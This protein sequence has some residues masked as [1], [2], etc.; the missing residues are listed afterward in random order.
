VAAA[1]ELYEPLTDD[2][3]Q[4]PQ[5]TITVDGEKYTGVLLD[6]LALKVPADPQSVATLEGVRSDGR[7][8]ASIRFPLADIG[9]TTVLV[10]AENGHVDLVSSSIPRD[11]WLIS[12]TSIAFQ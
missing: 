9:S 8:Y 10:I 4:L 7:R 2:F 1:G 6:T 3:N 11:Q 12:V 5:E